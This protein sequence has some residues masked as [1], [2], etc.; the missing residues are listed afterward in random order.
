VSCFTGRTTTVLCR[1]MLCHCRP[2]MA[3]GGRNP[4]SPD[5]SCDFQGAKLCRS[6]RRGSA[7]CAERLRKAQRF[8]SNSKL[9]L[10]EYAMFHWPVFTPAKTL[11]AWTLSAPVPGGAW[12]RREKPPFLSQGNLAFG[13]VQKTHTDLVLEVLIWRVREGCAK[14]SFAAAL[15]NSRFLPQPRNTAG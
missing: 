4:T 5:Q 2:L 12:H 7:Q 3:A 1:A 15:V 13:T 9:K 8:G 14:W 11:H 6:C 10:E